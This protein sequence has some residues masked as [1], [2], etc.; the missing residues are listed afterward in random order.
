MPD[1]GLPREVGTV[2]I[3]PLLSVEHPSAL[4]GYGMAVAVATAVGLTSLLFAVL[5][6]LPLRDPEGF[7]GPSYVRLPAVVAI[8]LVLDVLP[9][10][11][12]RGGLGR[13]LV[14]ATVQVARER[15]SWRRLSV[16]ATGLLSFYV[17][18]VGYRNLKSFLPFIRTDRVDDELERIDLWLTGGVQPAQLLHDLLGTGITPHV[19]SWVY[20]LFL[21]FVP[22]SLAVALVWNDNVSHGTWY[23]TALCLNWALGVV[24]YYLL[25]SMGPV[26][27]QTWTFWGTLLPPTETAEMQRSLMQSRWLVLD[28]PHATERV[29]SIAAFASLHVSIVFSAL[30]IVLKMH[31]HVL[32][33]AVMWLYFVLTVIAT[34]YFGWHYIVD[35]IAGLGIGA[36]SVWLGAR[37]T[38]QH[39]HPQSPLV[40]VQEKRAAEPPLPVGSTTV[41][42]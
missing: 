38:G 39:R 21:L 42:S 36:L 20:L 8:V 37:A 6:D 31:W 40:P 14:P 35:D 25:P 27:E 23:V 13:G 3:V 15:W 4:R 5:W 12:M 32:V 41:G 16:V 9:R 11:V 2:H 18:Y 19:L 34:I 1:S 28:D 7:L 24:S 30:L 33:K 29:H 10:A 22:F 26:Y 17:T